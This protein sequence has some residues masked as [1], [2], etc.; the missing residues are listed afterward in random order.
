MVKLALVDVECLG[1]L[2]QLGSDG[3]L[4]LPTGLQ[5]LHLPVPFFLQGRQGLQVPIQDAPLLLVGLLTGFQGGLHALQLRLP[6][7]ETLVLLLEP[8]HPALELNLSLRELLLDDCHI[9]FLLGQG[10][11]EPL[12]LLGVL[13][14][15]V[16]QL[17]LAS[18]ELQLETFQLGLVLGG[19]LCLPDE[20]FSLL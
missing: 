8:L 5:L 12:Y 20:T 13:V 4:V 16:H 14:V 10:V 15:L 6:Y 11:L 2:V 7:V 9:L 17:V 3:L 18:L 19:A 1:V